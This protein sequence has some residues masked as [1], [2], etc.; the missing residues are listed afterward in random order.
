MALPRCDD[1]GLQPCVTE[2]ID[3][4]RA[5]TGARGVH[6]GGCTACER[7]VRSLAVVEGEVFTE[8]QRE[9]GHRRM[10][11]QVHVFV[12]HRAPQPL[13]EDASPAPGP[14]PSLLMAMPAASGMLVKDLLVN[15]AP[16]PVLKTSGAPYASSASCRQSTQ[17][18]LS[19][20]LPM[21]QQSTFLEYQSKRATRYMKP[22][23]MGR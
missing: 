16:W 15:W 14:L 20:L 7:L 11:L 18:A 19:M 1:A 13:H 12:L 3:E 9:L 23:A 10:A 8:A 4:A 6:L 17:N 5:A 2:M 21:R 22:R